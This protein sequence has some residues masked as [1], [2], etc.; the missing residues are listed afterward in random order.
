MKIRLQANKLEDPTVSHISLVDH[1][2]NRIPF[3]IIKRNL[4]EQGMIDLNRIFKQDRP[5]PKTVQPKVL[6]I[7]VEKNEHVEAIKKAVT[8]AGFV[9]KAEEVQGNVVV[10]KADDAPLDMAQVDVV[11]MSN[12]VLALIPKADMQALHEVS[13][14]FAEGIK[15]NGFMPSVS[16]AAME[17]HQQLLEAAEAGEDVVKKAE[18]II[19]AYRSYALKALELLPTTL[20]KVD[21]AVFVAKSEC[22]PKE[23]KPKQDMAGDEKPGEGEEDGKSAAKKGE[24][25]EAG[26][27]N[28]PAGEAAPAGEPA[29]EPKPEEQP[30]DPAAAVAD[31]VQ[32]ALG[33]LVAQMTEISTG[34]VALKGEVASVTKSQEALRDK[35]S[36]AEEVAKAA[37]DAVKG[38]VPMSPPPGDSE[39]QS[40]TVQKADSP[41]TGVFDTAFMPRRAAKRAR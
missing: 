31:A 1:A 16:T 21:S 7:V 11:K 36:K 8:E 39:T 24:S 9:V 12:E 6:G 15:A 23:D 29:P 18:M 2:A 26:A 19:D 27:E 14:P 33:P 10:L 30:V 35:V 5:A 3:R 22:K 41:Y 20:Y 38:T 4:Q 34:L 32:K 37:K 40:A 25:A 28:A 17:M 13:G